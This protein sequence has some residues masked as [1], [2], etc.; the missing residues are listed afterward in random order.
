[1]KIMFL[2]RDHVY[3]CTYM[4]M[5]IYICTYKYTPYQT[6]SK[7]A[8]YSS[9]LRSSSIQVH[10]YLITLYFTIYLQ[11]NTQYNTLHVQ[12]YMQ[13]TRTHS[14]M[15]FSGLRAHVYRNTD[16][17]QK[18]DVTCKYDQDKISVSFAEYRSLL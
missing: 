18:H 7:Y 13:H 8:V 2:G 12:N 16:D 1:M 4:Y 17:N 14:Q 6:I 15:K 3:V 5:Y 9:T 10:K 11:K